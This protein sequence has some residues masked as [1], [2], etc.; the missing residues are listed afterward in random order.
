MAMRYMEKFGARIADNGY[1]VIPITPGYKY[2][3]GEG[4]G[5]WQRFDGSAEGVSDYLSNGWGGHGIGVKARRSPAVDMDL[6]DEDVLAEVKEIVREIAG[7]SPLR[8]VGFA[9]KELWVYQSDEPWPKVDTGEWL[10]NQGRKCKVE[11]LADG[12][13]FV[14]AHIHPDTGKP[15]QWIGG[16]SVLD[17]PRKNL[18]TLSHEQAN[19]I[20]ERVLSL[21]LG[22]GWTKKTKS[23]ITRLTN[24]LDDD[25]PFA[26]YRPKVQISDEELERRLFMIEDNT[27]HDTWFQI[28]M[29]LYHQYDGKQQGFDLWD[30][31]SQGAPNYDFKAL[32]KRW[33]TF[34]NKDLAHTPI[35]CRIILKLSKNAEEADTKKKVSDFVASLM[36]STTTDEL[37]TVCD[38]I[39]VIEL[40]THVRE[41]LTGKVKAKWKDLTGDNPRIGFIR[42]LIKYESKEMISAP[43]WVKPWVYC[44]QTDELFNIHNRTQ[45]SRPAF[46]AAY[47]RYMLTPSERL[48]GKATPEIQPTDA[49]LNLYQIPTVYNRMFMPGQPPLYTINGV[50]Y[51]N[52][53]TEDGIPELPGVMSPVEEEAVE[54]FLGHFK[55]IIADERD[56]TLFL[57][58]I[59]HVTQ[60]PGQRVNWAILLQGAEGDGKS[61]FIEILKAVLGENN[62]DMIPGK[63]LEEK[64]NP[65][66]ENGLI[67]FIEDV[68]L[69]GNNRFDAV[70]TLKPMI[71]NSMVSIRRMQ[72]NPYTVINTMSYIATANSKD[73]LPVGEEDSRF[74]PIFT[75]FQRPQDIDK[76]KQDN[77]HYYDRLYATTQFAGA[78]RQYLLLR[79]VS[80]EFNHKARAPKS[81]YRREMVLLNQT[82]ETAALIDALEESE[83]PDF[84]ELLLNSSKVADHFMGR[85]ALAPRSKA[86]N[87]LLS[88]FGF[89]LLGRFKV[90][91]AKHQFWTMRPH[92]WPQDENACA[93][94]I[95]DYL[96]P[97]GL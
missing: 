49:V 63:A 29:A 35:T 24:P 55:H 91:G 84:S 73:A 26:A 44:S 48:E 83:A 7:E 22:H 36:A 19:Q 68:R 20:K 32:E 61:Y 72:T 13:Q 38:E 39:K 85:D 78:I 1:E 17:T 14:A 51:A 5:K 50:D 89:T 43:P 41:L 59:T 4:M 15:Y 21:F 86:L 76:F 56:R 87:R 9:P 34:D 81:S 79:K 82:D 93:D 54:I 92:A 33:P 58:F 64:Y 6:L 77:P 16:A 12:Q 67:C 40:P 2:P 97:E 69:H 37:V 65:W 62:V 42:D 95:R 90:D 11:I 88:S 25:D 31:W 18:P 94:A 45:L 23:A 30:R 66:A 47:S 74:F 57:D 28:G 10:D 96:D 75:R 53:Y 71:T 27:D 8:R 3:A 52:S 60:N 80:P 70:N 46:N